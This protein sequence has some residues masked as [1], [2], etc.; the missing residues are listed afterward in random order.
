MPPK[1][2]RCEQGGRQRQPK[3][4]GEREG[5][6]GEGPKQQKQKD[7]AR[8]G[9]VLSKNNG[10]VD[11]RRA[12]RPSPYV[13]AADLP[14]G[15][16][17]EG[18]DGRTYVVERSSNGVHQWRLTEE[19]RQLSKSATNKAK[20]VLK[21][22]LVH[23]HDDDEDEDGPPPSAAADCTALSRGASC[24]AV[25][26]E[27]AR[28]LNTVAEMYTHPLGDHDPGSC[29][30]E[31]V[32]YVANDDEFPPLQPRSG[33]KMSR[34]MRLLLEG[35]DDPSKR[36]TCPGYYVVSMACTS[37]EKRDKVCEDAKDVYGDLSADTWKE[38]VG[39]VIPG[40]NVHLD[41]QL[42]GTCKA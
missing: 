2:P 14:P 31:S 18:N 4:K 35:S 10:A 23:L 24:L 11:P 6:G 38:G 41:L 29:Y 3:G 26:W 1:N 37:S 27:S 19:A 9:R 32:R 33:A 5:G 40:A 12:S 20:L 30:V 25:V 7:L 28:T 16:R 8:H 15:K 13:H 42:L 21:P 17:R 36:R 22:A 34:T 39:E